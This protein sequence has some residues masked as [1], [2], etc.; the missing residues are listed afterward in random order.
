MIRVLNYLLLITQFVV[1]GYFYHI[2]D[3]ATMI[4]LII[5]AWKTMVAHSFRVS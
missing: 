3:G 4:L 2:S 1:K 5:Q